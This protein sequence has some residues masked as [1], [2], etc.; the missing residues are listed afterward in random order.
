MNLFLIASFCKLKHS[1][2]KQP[3]GL[4]PG[5]FLNPLLTASL[6]RCGLKENTAN[7]FQIVFNLYL[8]YIKG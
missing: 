6:R 1:V 2:N 5:F 8:V 7:F 4:P 3:G